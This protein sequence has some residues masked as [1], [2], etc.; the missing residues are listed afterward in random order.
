MISTSSHNPYCV[1]ISTGSDGDWHF[2]DESDNDSDGDWHFYE[3]NTN[4]RKELEDDKEY[5]V[6]AYLMHKKFTRAEAREVSEKIG[7]EDINHLNLIKAQDVVE[8]NLRPATYIKFVELERQEGKQA[9]YHQLIKHL[10]HDKSIRTQKIPSSMYSL[11]Y[12][13]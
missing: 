7:L 2:A 9:T 1:N 5:P 10:E 12:R 11:M 4:E 6:I 8:A 3:E 13:A